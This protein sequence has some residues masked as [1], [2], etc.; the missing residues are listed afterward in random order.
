VF[1]LLEDA[2]S[3]GVADGDAGRIGRELR[4]VY[5]TMMTRA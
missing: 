4:G 3:A 2:P 5:E 1:E